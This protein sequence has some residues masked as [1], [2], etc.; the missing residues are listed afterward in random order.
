MSV[1]RSSECVFCLFSRSSRPASVARRPFHSSPIHQ[2][3]KPR[4]PSVKAASNEIDIDHEAKEFPAA[5]SDPRRH[6]YSPQQRAAIEAAEKLIDPEKLHQQTA[7]R[8]DPW[9]VNYYDDLTKINP[10]VDK[11]VRAPWSNTDEK[12]RLKT[13]DELAEDVV[14]FLHE[15]PRPGVP[16]NLDSKELWLQFDK[17]QRLTVG[18]EEAEKQPRTALAPDLPKISK[19]IAKGHQKGPPSPNG[20][21]RQVEPPSAGL[22]QLMQM[23]GYT[24]QEISKLRVKIII[25]HSVANQTRL[26]KIRKMYYLCVAG[27]GNGMIGI[28]EG[29]A[30]EMADARLQ[31]EYRAIRN[32]RPIL[33]YEDRTIFGDV[34]AKVSATELELYARPPGMSSRQ[35]L[36]ISH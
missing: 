36:W 18:R 32:M 29:K 7:V 10:V 21:P 5:K 6:Q 23:T 26:G 28:G 14:K 3:R 25:G 8:T 4:F 34:G 16:T 9:K 22:V 15:L 20:Q 13:D 24:Q 35:L 19:A 31:A 17:N 33:R 2:K 1:V 30:V 27:N 12:S 11:P